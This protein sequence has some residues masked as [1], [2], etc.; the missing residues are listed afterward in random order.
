MKKLK[1]YPKMWVYKVNDRFRAGIPDII[2]WYDGVPFAIELKAGS[3]KAT[4]IQKK[5]LEDMR[6]AGARTLIAYNTDTVDKFIE[7]VINGR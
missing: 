3:N 4:G 7:E 1:T 2:G 6:L 5:T